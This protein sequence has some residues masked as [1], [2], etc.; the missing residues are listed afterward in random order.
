MSDLVIRPARPDDLPALL[1]LVVELATYEREPDAVEATAEQM[2]LT[3]FPA[4]GHPAVF[5]LVA[6]SPAE[7]GPAT[8]ATIVGMAIWY[9]TYSTWLGRHGIWLEDLYVTPARR[10]SGA[11]KA[12]LTELAR[13]AAERGYGRLEWWVLRW[14]TPS[15]G[16]YES[17]GAEAMD[18]W[19]HYR[20]DGDALTALAASER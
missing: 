16:F 18:E 7:D 15:I 14:N 11:G 3:F 1:G 17:L 10:G 13:I 12:L 9:V 20:L 4:D 5:A 6:E 8:Q 19:A 2:V